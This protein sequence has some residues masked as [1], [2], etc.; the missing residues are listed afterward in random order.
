MVTFINISELTDHL[1]Q[2]VKYPDLRR[3]IKVFHKAAS[4]ADDL[5]IARDALDTMDTLQDDRE[6]LKLFGKALMSHAII[7]YSRATHSDAP[8][9]GGHIGATKGYSSEQ[10]E[11]HEALIAL[12]NQII[13]HAGIARHSF[14]KSWRIEAP[15]I[16]EEHDGFNIGYTSKHAMDNVILRGR[17]RDLLEKALKTS[18]KKRNIARDA[19]AE[20]WNRCRSD[21]ELQG[22]LGNFLDTYERFHEVSEEIALEQMAN[23]RYKDPI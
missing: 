15:Y 1:D 6:R 3:A 9:R 23:P 20:I 10:K 11:T 7:L 4:V 5:F 16:W 13:A 14:S 2:I 21:Q 22:M 12:R 8:G 18:V 19:L 17:F